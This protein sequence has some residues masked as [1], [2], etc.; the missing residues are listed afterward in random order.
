MKIIEIYW[1]WLEKIQT[2]SIHHRS[3]I[4]HDTT[5]DGHIF[6]I[7]AGES[8]WIFTSEPSAGGVFFGGWEYWAKNPRKIA[9]D[10]D[11][12]WWIMWWIVKELPNRDH[13]HFCKW[14]G[15]TIVTSRRDV[16]GTMVRIHRLSAMFR[17]VI[18][19]HAARYITGVMSH[20][21]KKY[22]PKNVGK[23]TTNDGW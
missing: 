4:W 17:L 2:L 8:P 18:Y 23:T 21:Y 7:S 9:V 19:Y 20:M 5:V 11:E 10:L 22:I 13:S 6:M 14:S 16:A 12:L 15:W 1:R 3:K